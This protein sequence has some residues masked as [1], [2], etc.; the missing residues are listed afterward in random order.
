MPKA[1]SGVPYAEATSGDNAR[2]EIG[3]I[4]RGFGCSAIG[5]M[6]DFEKGEVVL[7]F[8]HHGL[9]VQMKASAHGWAAMYLRRKPYDSARS[10]KTAAEYKATAIAQ[11]HIAVNSVLRDWVK[12]QVTAIECGVLNVTEAFMP[13]TLGPDGRTMLEV[14]RAKN[15]LPAP[16]N[17]GEE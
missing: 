16:T 8:T 7:A 3:K 12:G 13:W 9:N 15:L 11:G 10:R 5:F 6:D 1:V 4:L 17:A 2:N 14:M